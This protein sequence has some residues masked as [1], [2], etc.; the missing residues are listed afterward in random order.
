MPCILDAHVVELYSEIHHKDSCCY[1]YTLTFDYSC[2]LVN[3]LVNIP[4]DVMMCEN[5]V[6]EIY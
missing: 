5:S 3:D 4:I 2:N 1:T 6:A